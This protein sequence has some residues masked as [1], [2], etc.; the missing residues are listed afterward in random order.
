[1]AIVPAEYNIQM[2]DKTKKF[3]EDTGIVLEGFLV[4]LK[5]KVKN[6]DKFRS[7]KIEKLMNLCRGK[8]NN[9]N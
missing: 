7:E 9:I 8:K 2:L 6:Y 1:M 5:P 3:F 4:K